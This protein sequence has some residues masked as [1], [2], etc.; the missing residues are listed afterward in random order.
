MC[1]V[2]APP[3]CD[4]ASPFQCPSKP[5]FPVGSQLNWIKELGISW[6][7]GLGPGKAQSPSLDISPSI[8]NQSDWRSHSAPT[9]ERNNAIVARAGAFYFSSR[10]MGF[11]PQTV[12][13]WQS[14][15]V[16]QECGF[17]LKPSWQILC[18][19]SKSSLKKTCVC[20]TDTDGS[21]SSNNN[22]LMNVCVDEK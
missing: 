1:S 16:F 18:V 14:S 17:V 11:S 3:P 8:K 2:S 12:E 6:G 20:L 10:N 15:T 9:T 5:S 22:S 7:P 19:P 13:Q 21:L 4:S